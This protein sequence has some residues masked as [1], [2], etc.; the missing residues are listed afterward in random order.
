MYVLVCQ[1]VNTYVVSLASFFSPFEIQLYLLSASHTE[2]IRLNSDQNI[3]FWK[4]RIISSQ[5]LSHSDL[6]FYFYFSDSLTN[7]IFLT[8]CTKT[9]IQYRK[10][11]KIYFHYNMARS[12]VK[13]KTKLEHC[14][15]FCLDDERKTKSFMHKFCSTT[16][17]TYT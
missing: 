4:A 3:Y 16:L 12:K 2:P 13:N 8:W 17:Q 5:K 6:A 11:K 15:A 1:H 7:Q 14:A 10:N 9:S